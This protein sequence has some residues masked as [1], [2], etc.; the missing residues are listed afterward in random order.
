MI[1]FSSAKACLS[2]FLSLPFSPWRR[3][4]QA[5]CH[6]ALTHSGGAARVPWC[7]GGARWFAPNDPVS[8]PL[9]ANNKTGMSVLRVRFDYQYIV[10]YAAVP[11]RR[12][13]SMRAPPRCVLTMLTSARCHRWFAVHAANERSFVPLLSCAA[14]SL[15][16]VP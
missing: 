12:A 5:C 8:T 14:A 6:R 11:C 4:P 3:P 1:L 15:L 7:R 2:L 16:F 13:L 10:G 9:D